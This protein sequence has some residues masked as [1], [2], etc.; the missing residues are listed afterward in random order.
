MISILIPTYDED[1]TLLVSTL[2]KQASE[3]SHEA[4]ILVCDQARNGEHL[5]TN[6]NLNR[7]KNVQYF[8][9][10]EKKGRSANRNYLASIAANEWL[11]FLDSDTEVISE[12]FIEDFYQ[13][14]KKSAAIC[15]KM[16]YTSTD[17]GSELRL[18]WKYGIHREMKSA[19]E[20]NQYPHRS[21]LSYAFLIHKDDFIK[22]KFDEDIIEYGHE[23]TLFGKRL[24]HEFIEPIHTDIPLLHLG[25]IPAADFLEKVRQSVRSLR[26]LTEKGWVDEDFKLYSVQQKLA[27]M[28]L[29][30]LM[31]WFFKAFHKMM[32]KQLT[33]SHPSL[34]VLD[35]YKLS[36][37]CTFI[38]GVKIS[39]KTLRS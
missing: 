14:R 32:E 33:S 12:S 26:V 7:L 3:L 5:H 11:L 6:Q 39:S 10:T 30:G 23:D 37:F 8:N 34:T 20:R 36:Y 17:P 24:A 31:G 16:V 1:V 38:K 21:F 13:L 2:S 15:G 22:V 28:K 27:K 19:A 25:L 29:D 9:W 35:I 18:R 4:E